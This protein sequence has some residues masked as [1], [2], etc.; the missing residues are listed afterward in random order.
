MVQKAIVDNPGPGSYSTPDVTKFKQV[1]PRAIFGIS[2][3]TVSIKENIGEVRAKSLPGPGAY[4]LPRMF[5][6]C[7]DY[8]LPPIK[9]QPRYV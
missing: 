7:P 9:D 3:R 2:K 5:A 4:K 6:D 8:A 1:A